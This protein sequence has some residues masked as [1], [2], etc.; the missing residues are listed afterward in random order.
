MAKT[1]SVIVYSTTSCPWCYRAK[2][3]L[4]EHK[5]KYESVDVGADQKRAEEMIEKSGQMGVPVIDVNG[6]IIIGFDEEKL[7]SA[8]GVKD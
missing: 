6:R 4:D 8:L 3:W 7:K 2:Q 1:N 5:I